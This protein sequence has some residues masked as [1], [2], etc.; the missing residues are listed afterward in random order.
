VLIKLG[1]LFADKLNLYGDLGNVL[2]IKHRLE[3]RG[4]QVEINNLNDDKFS[5]VDYD[6]LFIGGGQDQE[7][8]NVAEILKKKK[9][10][11]VEFVDAGKPMLAICGGYQL[12][13]ESYLTSEKEEIAGLGILNV[14]TK[15]KEE[16]NA[17]DFQDRLVGNVVAELNFDLESGSDLTSLVGFENHSGRTFI[18]D[19]R[20]QA[21]AKVKTGF[22]NNDIDQLEGARYKNLF[23]SYLHGSLLPKNPHLADEIIF[24]LLKVKT[25]QS[26][27]LKP[28][29][30]NIELKAHQKALL[31]N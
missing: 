3:A 29:D 21:L 2:A 9:Q 28:L 16:K 18:T 13:G 25:S 8:V 10:E 4:F 12:L 7:Q 1:H 26:H 24:L 15:A 31:L 20:T 14:V 6:F 19:A 23:A 5:L 22:G 27:D 17:K 11:L 30:D